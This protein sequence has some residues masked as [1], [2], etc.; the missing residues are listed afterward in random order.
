MPAT[1]ST[2]RPAPWS[3]RS[4][5]R[6]RSSAPPTAAIRTATS[7]RATTTRTAT[8]SRRRSPRSR[9][10]RAAR[11]F[12][13]GLAA[14]TAIFQGLQ[15]G[16]HVVAPLDIYH[17]TANVLK[18]LFAKW[19]VG[20]SFVDMTRARR[21]RPRHPAAH[22]HRLDRDAVQ[23]AAAMRR[24]RRGRRPGP[25]FRRAARSPTTPSPRRRCSGRSI[26]AATW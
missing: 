10:V 13:S 11:A 22:A 14:V 20:A 2:R 26:S 12:A 25:S 7:I 21:H 6:R 24:H 9:V 15:P 5:S 4:T 3:R 23:S 17:G 8:A 1:T 18:H 16:D 19:Q